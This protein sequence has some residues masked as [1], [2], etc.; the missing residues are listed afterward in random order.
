MFSFNIYMEV[1]TSFL[2]RPNGCNWDLKR[3]W[4]FDLTCPE[5]L[6]N[7]FTIKPAD[8]ISCLLWNVSERREH[9]FYNQ[10]FLRQVNCSIHLSIDAKEIKQVG[11]TRWQPWFFSSCQAFTEWWEINKN[12]ILIHIKKLNICVKNSPLLL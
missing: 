8:L 4:E 6:N 2:C 11:P 7:Y 1:N 12:K 9:L 10:C 5:H 3:S